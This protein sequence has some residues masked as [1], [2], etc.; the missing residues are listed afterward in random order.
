M[1]HSILLYTF[2][3]RNAISHVSELFCCYSCEYLSKKFKL[4]LLHFYKENIRNFNCN[5]LSSH[6]LAK[7]SVITLE[8]V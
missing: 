1:Q 2:C 4:T 3:I 7:K 6:C 5:F 8:S